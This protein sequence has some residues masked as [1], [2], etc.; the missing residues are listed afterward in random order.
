MSCRLEVVKTFETK[1]RNEL[2]I[3]Q[4]WYKVNNEE[5]C[6]NVGLGTF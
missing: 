2:L 5:V 3:Y 4:L 6:E 1:V